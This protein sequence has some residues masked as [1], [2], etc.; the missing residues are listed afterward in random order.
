MDAAERVA[1]RVDH[2]REHSIGPQ[3][4]FRGGRSF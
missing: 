3:V 4:V 2:L 1:P